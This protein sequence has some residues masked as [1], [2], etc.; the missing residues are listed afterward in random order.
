MVR[1]NILADA[2]KILIRPCSKVIMRFLTVMM[3]HGY[4]GEF[5]VIDDHRAGKVVVN[6]TG[7]LTPPLAWSSGSSL[8]LNIYTAVFQ[9]QSPNHLTWA[10][11][12]FFMPV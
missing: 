4:I 8:S 2:L 12:E 6:L 10:S 1:M 9:S 7:R 5:E 11:R 3:K